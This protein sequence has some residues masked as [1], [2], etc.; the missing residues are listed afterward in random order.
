MKKKHLY[1]AVILLSFLVVGIQPALATTYSLVPGT[2]ISG[3]GVW[4]EGNT[5][6]TFTHDLSGHDIYMQDKIGIPGIGITI[7]GNNH[8]ITGPSSSGVGVNIVN[9]QNITIKNLNV[10]EFTSSNLDIGIWIQLSYNITLTSNSVCC[11]SYGIKLQ[12]NYTGVTQGNALTNNEVSNNLQYAIYLYGSTYNTLTFNTISDNYRG[13]R[14]LDGSNYNNVYNNHITNNTLQAS[15]TDS[16]GNI[17]NLPSAQGGGNYWSNWSLTSDPPQ[18]DTNGDGFVDAP[19]VFNGAQDALPWANP[20]GPPPPPSPQDEIE[21]LIFTVAEMNL[22]HGIDNSLDAKLDAAFNALD[23]LNQNND[24]AAINSLNAFINAAEA[25][26]DN[27][28]TDTQADILITDAQYIID[29]I[30]AE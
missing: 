23:D 26:R 11:N 19:Y 20:D 29:L 13:I 10:T 1:K 15:V 17:F 30:L 6:F 7:D 21:A 25:Q 27:K 4:S 18:S 24:V 14:I 9:C 12:G 8:T 3:V 2:D 16:I 28:I 22:Q 5:V